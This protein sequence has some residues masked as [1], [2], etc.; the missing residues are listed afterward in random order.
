MCNVRIAQKFKP[1][2]LTV[3]MRTLC[4]RLT[5]AVALICPFHRTTS[6]TLFRFKMAQQHARLT[7]LRGFFHRAQLGTSAVETAD[8]EGALNRLDLNNTS[9]VGQRSVQEAIEAITIG[10][11]DEMFRRL[12]AA[13]GGDNTFTMKRLDHVMSLIPIFGDYECV[14][15]YIR[16]THEAEIFLMVTTSKATLYYTS[17]PARDIQKSSRSF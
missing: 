13:F 9:P 8:I 3:T 5:A 4:G 1:M 16:T 7:S 10:E 12:H 14:E 11:G 15:D 2:A 17:Q 6:H